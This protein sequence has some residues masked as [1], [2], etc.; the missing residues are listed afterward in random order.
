MWRVPRSLGVITMVNNSTIQKTSLTKILRNTNKY[1]TNDH[2]TMWKCFLW[3][4]TAPRL[5]VTPHHVKPDVDKKPDISAM[6]FLT[7]NLMSLTNISDKWI[8]ILSPFNC[9]LWPVREALLPIHGLNGTE[10]RPLCLGWLCC[11]VGK[12]AVQETLLFWVLLF[13]NVASCLTVN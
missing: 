2:E 10:W 3:E 1:D 12:A 5:N 7:V 11:C 9:K 13:G 4:W 6:F 8:E